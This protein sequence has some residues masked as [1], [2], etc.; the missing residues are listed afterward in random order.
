MCIHTPKGEN[1]AQRE[2]ERRTEARW[3]A[4]EDGERDTQK[5]ITRESVCVCMRVRMRGRE[6]VCVGP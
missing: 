6:Y 3:L 1:E 2:R 4:K 5:G